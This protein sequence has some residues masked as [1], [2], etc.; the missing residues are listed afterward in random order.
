MI[1]LIQHRHLSQG[2]QPLLHQLF[3]PMV[4]EA[5]DRPQRS[6][7]GQEDLS[8][9]ALQTG[10]VAPWGGIIVMLSLR[11]RTLPLTLLM[12]NPIA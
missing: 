3:L 1:P 7:F 4:K 5:W 11:P 8:L 6:I 12:Q 2:N 10:S 9:L